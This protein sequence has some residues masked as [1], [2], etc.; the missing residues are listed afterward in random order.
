MPRSTYGESVKYAVDQCDSAFYY[1]E[2]SGH[3]YS[4]GT[5]NPVGSIHGKSEGRACGMAALALKAR[6]LLYAASPLVNCK[7]EDDPNLLVSYGDYDAARWKTAYDAVKRFIDL[8][9]ANSW[10]EL[11]PG[12]KDNTTAAKSWWPRFYYAFMHDAVTNKEPI[13]CDFLSNEQGDSQNRVA[14][15]AYYSPNSR[16]SR[17]ANLNKLTGFPTQELV[18]A[19]PMADG[20]PIRDSRSKY[21]YEDGDDMYLNRDPRLKATVSY[22]GAYRMMNAYKDA[23]M[24]TYTGDMVTTGNPDETSAIKDG[25][26]QPNATTTG[27]YRMKFILDNG[28][29]ETYDYR[30]TILMR[31]AEILLIAAETANELVADGALAPEESKEYIRMIRQRAEIE[32]GESNKYGVMDDI[33]KEDMRKLI[34]TERQIELAFEEHRYWDVRRWKIAKEVLGGPSHGMEITRRVLDDGGESFSYRRIE[35]LNHVWDDRLYWW[36]VPQ[37]EMSKSGALIQNPGY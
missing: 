13:F 14:L 32:E 3:I 21:T 33:K 17:F 24:R 25:I 23:L 27:Y 22:N 15:D 26:Y 5:V 35:V 2:R 30:P 12:Q 28:G 29:L 6:I 7:R 9:N 4:Q 18:D 36:P 16:I 31:Y 11:R 1:L 8:N 20:F 37:S 19:F 34:Q 10:Y